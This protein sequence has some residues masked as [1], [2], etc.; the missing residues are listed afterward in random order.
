MKWYIFTGAIIII[1]AGGLFF[2]FSGTPE[3]P[4][5]NQPITSFP[6][7]NSTTNVYPAGS[8][9]T[10]TG[11]AGIS[12]GVKNGGG[13]TVNDFIHN[14]ETI[15]D[16]VNPGSYVLAGSLGYC[17]ADGSCPS[18]ASTTDFSISYNDKIHFFNIILLTEPI[19]SARQSAEQFLLNRLG[20]SEQEACSLDYSIGAPYWVNEAY[21]GK[22]LGFSFCQGA[23]KLPE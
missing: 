3:T 9:A 13:I 17:L 21:D 4:V 2:I 7:A 22:N 16:A 8:S 6:T 23:T 20:I 1:I 15:A 18:G 10:S 5:T 12:I 19:G 14:G 11:T